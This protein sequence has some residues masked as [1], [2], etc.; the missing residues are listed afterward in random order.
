MRRI[1]ELFDKVVSYDLSKIQ[2]SYGDVY[3]AFFS[4]DSVDYIVEV[5]FIDGVWDI[6]FFAQSYS[7]SANYEITGTGNQFTIFSTVGAIILEFVEKEHPRIFKFES[8]KSE[9]SRVQLYSIF[10]KEIEK[11]TGYRSYSKDLRTAKIFY[12]ERV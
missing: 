1:K 7:I 10:A 8:T 6:T 4:I 5:V 12:F 9:Q 3:K 11:R 2:Y